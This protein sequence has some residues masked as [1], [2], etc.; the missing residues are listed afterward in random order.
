MVTPAKSTECLADKTFLPRTN[1]NKCLPKPKSCRNIDTQN[2]TRIQHKQGRNLQSESNER[3]ESDGDAAEGYWIGSAP[4]NRACRGPWWR[5]RG[6][7]SC[8]PSSSRRPSFSAWLVLPCCGALTLTSPIRGRLC[9]VPLVLLD[10]VWIFPNS[11]SMLLLLYRGI[12][13]MSLSFI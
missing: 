9:C 6:G 11:E 2:Q 7:S 10:Q 5:C 8:P 4:T 3:T 1:R 12:Q 13:S